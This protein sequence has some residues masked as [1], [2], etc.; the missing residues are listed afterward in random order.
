VGGHH[1]PG[2]RRTPRSTRPG[3][4]GGVGAAASRR[5]GLGPA[6]A[7]GAAPHAAG[8]RGRRRP[9]E[10]SAATTL[11]AAAAAPGRRTGLTAII[12][13]AGRRTPRSARPSGAGGMVGAAIG[14]R[15]CHRRLNSPRI[16][17]LRNP[18]SCQAASRPD[19][20]HSLAGRPTPRTARN[21]LFTAD[22]RTIVEP[23]R[24]YLPPARP[25]ETVRSAEPGGEPGGRSGLSLPG[26]DRI[27]QPALSPTAKWCLNLKLLRY[28]FSRRQWCWHGGLVTSASRTL[29]TMRR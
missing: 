17:R 18:H 13:P 9:R 6:A 19:G 15:G 21:S 27:K 23:N 22:K 25:N 4:A 16:G 5:Q 20:Y 2:R 7:P 8:R 26:C 28:F 10:A 29:P 14:V 1:P 11:P 24:R 12:H 3:G